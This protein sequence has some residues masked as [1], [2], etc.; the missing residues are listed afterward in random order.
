[1]KEGN[2]WGSGLWHFDEGSES[3]SQAFLRVKAAVAV[4]QIVA[5]A[6]KI[7][8]E[9]KLSTRSQRAS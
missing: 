8:G 4:I 2:S 7:S 5:T 9:N 1:L 6:N 3:L